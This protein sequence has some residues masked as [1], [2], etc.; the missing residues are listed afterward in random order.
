MYS[1][2]MNDRLDFV[3][4]GYTAK[5]GFSF[6]RGKLLGASFVVYLFHHIT[7]YVSWSPPPIIII[8]GNLNVDD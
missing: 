7:R 8:N 6:E 5:T 2:G 4:S 1:E 3:L